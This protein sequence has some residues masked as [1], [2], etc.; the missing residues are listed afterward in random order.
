MSLLTVIVSVFLIFSFCS[1]AFRL[2]IEALVFSECRQ[3]HMEYVC[4][5]ECI[6]ES[7]LLKLILLEI[8]FLNVTLRSALTS[9]EV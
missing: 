2:P 4:V 3:L 9:N 7:I 1:V 6:S 5:A 8:Y